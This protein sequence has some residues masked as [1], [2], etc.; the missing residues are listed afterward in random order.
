M[1]MNDERLVHVPKILETEKSEDLHED[2]ENMNVLKLL[3]K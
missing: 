2:V 3:L 1:L